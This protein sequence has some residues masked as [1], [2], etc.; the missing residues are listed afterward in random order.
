[1][2]LG[3]VARVLHVLSGFVYA[4]YNDLQW[5]GTRRQRLTRLRRPATPRV[6]GLTGC[7]SHNSAWSIREV[8]NNL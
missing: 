4:T 1:M 5:N 3:R 2:R 7:H 8:D 6:T